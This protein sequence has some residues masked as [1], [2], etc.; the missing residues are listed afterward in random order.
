MF[1][2]LLLTLAVAVSLL[3]A[4]LGAQKVTLS[5][6]GNVADGAE[7]FSS[8]FENEVNQ[9]TAEIE[10]Q[11]DISIAVVSMASLAGKESGKVAHRIG[12]TFR[13]AGQLNENWVVFVLAPNE[14]EFSAAITGRADLPGGVGD[15]IQ[16]SEIHDRVEQF[17]KVF[18]S[19]VTPYF[20]NDEWEAGI[21]AG[22]D[23]LEDNI[24]RNP[25]K[26][27]PQVSAMAIS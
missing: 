23:A 15:D 10:R 24:R 27:S 25:I 7:L 1:R 22:I 13:D 17:A 11:T 26:E 5:F 3:S 16:R 20:K 9:R 2:P 4:P 21:R 18:S 19:A 8:T 14:R 12:E 6:N